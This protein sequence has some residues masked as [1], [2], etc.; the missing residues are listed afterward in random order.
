MPRRYEKRRSMLEITSPDSVDEC[1]HDRLNR[2]DQPCVP[3]ADARASAR[4]NRESQRMQPYRPSPLLR[5]DDDTFGAVMADQLRRA[6][7]V[8][9]SLAV[10]ATV[11]LLLWLVPAT[12]RPADV[13]V[14][15][16]LP[17][18]RPVVF[19]ET[20]P[21]PPDPVEP[22]PIEPERLLVMN[23]PRHE[24][25][26][27]AEYQQ[28]ESHVDTVDEAASDLAWHTN[29]G[30]GGGTPARYAGRGIGGARRG[31]FPAQAN[32]DAALVWLR[33]HQDDDG[34]WDCD[35]FMKH[36]REGAAC[37]G[38]GDPLHD[39]GV[40]ALALLAFLGDG[41]TLRA[42]RYRDVVK[43]AVD[44]LRQQQDADTGWI[45]SQA[46]HHAIYD[47]AIATLALCEAQGL[48]R[49]RSLRPHAQRAI[50][51]LNA[52]RN[53]YGAWRYQPRSGDNDMS[54]TGWALMALVSAHEFGLAVDQRALADVDAYIDE[55]TDAGGRVGYVTRGGPSSRHAGDHQAAFPT[56]RN[57]CM[58]GV[59]LLCKALL[60]H[61]VRTDA[62]M[63]QQLAV[64]MRKKPEW[65]IDALG[66]SLDF[67]AWYYGSYAV[68]QAGEPHWSSW[69]RALR[70]AVLPH[71]RRDGNAAGSWD[72]IDAWGRD[73]GR[74]YS[75]AILTLTLQAYY[76]YARTIGGR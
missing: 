34:R 70:E 65:R 39:V 68:F 46:S 31:G 41:N 26:V 33:D 17:A 5:T 6:P 10:H 7:W 35:E 59:G 48:S 66:S 36:D 2:R 49:Y 72:P 37:D 43:R 19:E 8:L 73:G 18:Q 15:T 58:T 29:V 64:L 23:E 54:I 28:T 38:A 13:V 1:A 67:Y 53:P 74:V 50:D 12:A 21:P 44:W 63:K 42:G 69:S 9:V 4:R 3:W 71:Q 75:T 20:P 51:C 61:D 11:L 22:E 56:D 32:V 27:P 14:A 62:R 76:R 60:D 45:G 16:V 40:T 55:M 47:H 24:A 57:E 30:L 52:V 25:E